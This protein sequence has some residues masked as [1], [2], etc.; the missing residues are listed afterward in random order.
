MFFLN[1]SE[2]VALNKPAW[3]QYPYSGRLWGA[4]RA[5]D[6]WYTD[7]SAAGGQCVISSNNDQ[8]A[9]WRVDLGKVLSIHHIFIKYRT[10]NIVWGKNYLKSQLMRLMLSIYAKKYFITSEYQSI[11]LHCYIAIFC[12]LSLLF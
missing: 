5:V 10:E 6:G 7:L 3:Q 1:S 12:A 9:E 8:T 2:N 11:Y 4:D